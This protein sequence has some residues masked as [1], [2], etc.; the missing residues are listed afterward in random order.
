M[1]LRRVVFG[2]RRARL[3][4]VRHQAVVGDVERD[5]IGR[6]LESRIGGGFIAD[7]PVVDHVAGRFRMQLRRARLNRIA[8]V[9]DGGQFLV[10]DATASAASRAWLL[11]LGDHDRD[12]LADEAH[13]LRRHRRPRAHLHRR[14]VLGMD[15]PAA[16]QIADLVLDQFLAGQHTDHAGHLERRRGV[17]RHHLGMGVRAADERGIGHAVQADV[18]DITALAGDEA[19]VF[20]AQRAGANAFDTHDLFS[21][22]ECFARRF[23]RSR[24][25]EFVGKPRCR[26]RYSAACATFMRPAASSTDLTM[27]W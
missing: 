26:R 1:L 27:L 4:R 14:A 3:H 9:G 13:G 10:V 20:L 17:D 21:L 11:R 8:H 2:D 5:H 23:H 16:D 25:L 15:H 22:S 12:R 24:R 18:V 7:G 19:L 6:S